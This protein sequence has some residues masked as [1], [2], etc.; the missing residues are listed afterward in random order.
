VSRALDKRA[1]EA[2]LRLMEEL[3][4]VTTESVMDIVRPHFMFDPRVAR[5][6]EI[7]RKANRLMAR[8]RDDKGVRTCFSYKDVTG[9][10]KY[11]NVDK[12]NDIEAVKAVSEQINDKYFGLSKA[13]KKLNARLL[14]LAGQTSLF[15]EDEEA[16]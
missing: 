10:S 2:I 5:E 12:T 6:R 16:Q 7:R 9:Q 1:V 3:D 11:V 8:F 15:G 4:E 13:K 14:E